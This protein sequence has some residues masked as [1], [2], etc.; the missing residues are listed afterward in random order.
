MR[1]FTEK[2]KIINIGTCYCDTKGFNEVFANLLHPV[3]KK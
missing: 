1:H 2:N 3:K